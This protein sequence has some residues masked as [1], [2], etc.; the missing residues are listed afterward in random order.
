MN[1]QLSIGIT[2]NPRTWPVIDGAVI[3]PLR[4]V[5]AD[6][7]TVVALYTMQKQPDK[8]WRISGCELAP[9]TLQSI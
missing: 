9:S 3:Q 4:L 6:G 8:E 2:S 7:E 5:T 1:I